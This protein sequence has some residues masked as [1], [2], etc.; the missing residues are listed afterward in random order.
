MSRE[1]YPGQPGAASV[2]YV[3]RVMNLSKDYPLLFFDRVYPGYSYLITG[4]ER[5]R[6]NREITFVIA[7]RF[8]GKYGIL[9]ST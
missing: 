3:Y 7:G 4:A 9:S 6:N 2:V 1:P 8:A 5:R